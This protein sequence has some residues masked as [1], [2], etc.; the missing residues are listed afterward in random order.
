MGSLEYRACFQDDPAGRAAANENII[1]VHGLDLTKW[2]ER[3]GWDPDYVPFAFFDGDTVVA[4][5]CIYVMDMRIRGEW[6]RAAQF[7]SV[8][9]LPDY[10]MRG[11]NAELT[12]RAVEW[13]REQGLRGTFLFSDDDATGFYAKQG[14]VERSEW[15]HR[16]M[17]R[18][19]PRPAHR[20]LDY[21][22]DEDLIRR[23]VEDRA[24]VSHLLGA[25]SP[26]HQLFHLLY[27]N[28][29]ELRYVEDLDL[30]VC[31]EEEDGE[32]RV[33][34]IIGLEMAPWVEIEPRVIGPRTRSVLF[35]ITPDRLDLEGAEPVEDRSSRLHVFP[36]EDL[37]QGQV[38]VPYTAHA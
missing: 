7:S 24:P 31:C 16:V 21:D 19:V 17:V 6:R 12:R 38:I 33:Y 11:L 36:D 5:S 35:E 23:L 8:G 28:A 32:L 15:K 10:R 20:L 30:F 1:A 22:K 14:F 13:I 2:D 3:V 9:T 18:S 4:L 27:E 25:R 37:V 29:G 26:K 34:D